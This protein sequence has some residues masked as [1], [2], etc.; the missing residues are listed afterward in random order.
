MSDPSSALLHDITRMRREIAESIRRVRERT[1]LGTAQAQAVQLVEGAFAT[2]NA[3]VSRAL[4]QL[5]SANGPDGRA[6]QV[7]IRD[8]L[9]EASIIAD[10]VATLPVA[11]LRPALMRGSFEPPAP[12]P[13]VR[14]SDRVAALLNILEQR[15]AA[16]RADGAALIVEGAQL[17]RFEAAQV[18][19]L[20][21][22]LLKF[23]QTRD[24]VTVF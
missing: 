9:A 21:E 11:E 22:P 15:G 17:T 23:C 5:T 12:P 19:E 20:K 18:R 14:E 3:R 10:R 24:K 16:V 8:A 6:L 1:D 2:A 7:A 4:P 13:P